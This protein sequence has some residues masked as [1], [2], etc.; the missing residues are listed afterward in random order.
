MAGWLLLVPVLLLGA[1][2]NRGP[3]YLP[4]NE[5]P[6]AP[7]VSG[8]PQTPASEL[9]DPDQKTTDMDHFNGSF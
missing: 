3:L 4:E 6:A 1:C 2:G 8:R 9:Q 7:T 5:P